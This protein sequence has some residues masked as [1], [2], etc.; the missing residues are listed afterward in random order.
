MNYHLFDP[1]NYQWPCVDWYVE[2]IST[3]DIDYVELVSSFLSWGS[4]YFDHHCYVT[5]EEW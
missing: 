3:H 1:T 4:I 2:D 5:E